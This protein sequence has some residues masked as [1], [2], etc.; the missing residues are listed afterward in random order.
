MNKKIDLV[1]RTIGERTSDIALDLA[2][3]QI[4]PNQ[5]HL[6]ENVR[7]FSA[8]VQQMLQ[9]DYDCDFVVFMD[10]DCLLMESMQAFLQRNEFPYVDCYVLDKFRGHIHQGVHITRVDVVRLMAQIKPPK[11]DEKYVLR[12]ESRLRSMALSRMKANKNFKTFRILHDYFQRYDH[13]YAKMALRELRS[14]TE[15]NR[16]E[17]EAAEQYWERHIEEVDFQ[18]AKLAIAQTRVAVP[19]NST[20]A[21]IDDYI[22]R[23]PEIAENAISQLDLPPQGELTPAEIDQQTKKI[24]SWQ[25][26]QVGA[27]TLEPPAQPRSPYKIFGLG[28]SRTG[29]KSLTSAL[30]ILGFK[31]I[32]YPEDETTLRELTE[33]N[34]KFS[35]LDH[36]DGITDITVSAFY[37]Q[38]DQLFPGSKFIL[39]VRDKESW[40]TSLEK[41]WFNRPAFDANNQIEKEIHLHIRRFLR[42]TVYGCYEFNRER[43]SYVY[44]LHYKNTLDYFCDR[45]D[46]LLVLNIGAGEGWDKLCPFL[47]LDPLAQP[48]P[49]IKKQ[50]LLKSLLN[51]EAQLIEPPVSA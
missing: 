17:L 44:D 43:M 28:L 49:Y 32:H 23:L 48:F 11:N 7:P 13:I 8:A 12:P 37:P 24:W 19:Q 16:R 30:H 2:I 4:Q 29:T 18:I 15:E 3:Q 9:I 21:E 51:A 27:G 33:G 42:S 6:I 39:T 14:R 41:H 38:L 47:G 35:L 40:L 10:A 50:S 31:V 26:V 34:Y 46:S 36:F 25:L 20:P 5:V 45:P 22:V 1:F